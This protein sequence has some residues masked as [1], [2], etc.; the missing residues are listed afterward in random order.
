MVHHWIIYEVRVSVRGVEAGGGE[1]GVG[2]GE[3][4]DLRDGIARDGLG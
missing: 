2:R 4:E 1:V 3:G